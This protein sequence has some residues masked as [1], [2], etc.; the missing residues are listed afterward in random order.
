MTRLK[1]AFQ[2]LIAALSRFFFKR[3]DESE[4]TATLELDRAAINKEL[5]KHGIA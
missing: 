1:H 3:R 4:L 5:Q 2:T